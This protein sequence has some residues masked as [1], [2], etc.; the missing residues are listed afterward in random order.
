MLQNLTELDI[1]FNQLVELERDAFVGLK[2]LQKL[3]LQNNTLGYSFFSFP[4]SV[5][6]S[7]ISLKYLKIKFNH[8]HAEYNLFKSDIFDLHVPTLRT[9]EIDVFHP[10]NSTDAG[11]FSTN[12][13]HLKALI[14]G[15]CVITELQE[16]TFD[17]VKYLEYIDLS[18][19]LIET[20]RSNTLQYRYIKYLDLS[21]TQ[22]LSDDVSVFAFMNDIK[23]CAVD[24]LVLSNTVTDYDEV[25]DHFISTLFKY[26]FCTRIRELRLSYNRLK[27]IEWRTN[28][29]TSE[30]VKTNVSHTET[31]QYVYNYDIPSTLPNFRSF[32]KFSRPI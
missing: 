29:I 18:S 30:M 12:S 31:E 10:V 9:L 22:F 26:L 8:K 6:T 2:R 4:D 24:R 20:Y 21:N 17:N 13:T 14:T 25:F 27:K 3:S 15:I 5:L 1:S 28:K 32:T 16:A 7:L 23:T 11:I 19:C